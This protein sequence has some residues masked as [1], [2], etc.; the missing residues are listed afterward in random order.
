MTPNVGGWDRTFRIVLGVIVIGLGIYFSSWWGA[1]GTIPLL[2]G[3]LGW[4]PVYL[5]FGMSTRQSRPAAHA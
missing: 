4:C 5:P 2:T 1:L 3:L